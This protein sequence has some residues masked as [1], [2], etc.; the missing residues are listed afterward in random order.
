MWFAYKRKGGNGKGCIIRFYRES[1]LRIRLRNAYK[2]SLSYRQALSVPFIVQYEDRNL[3][4][5]LHFMRCKDTIYS[6]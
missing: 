4:V 2:K 5:H 3:Q 6:Q 1:D